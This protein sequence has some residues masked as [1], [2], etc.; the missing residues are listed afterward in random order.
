MKIQINSYDPYHVVI[1]EL[2][3]NHECDQIVQ[4]LAKHLKSHPDKATKNLSL[5]G[6]RE[7]ADVRVMKK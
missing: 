2:L 1:K 5:L 3:Y 4:P 7:W 6:N